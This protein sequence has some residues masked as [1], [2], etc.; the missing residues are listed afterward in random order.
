MS[1]GAIEWIDIP[2]LDTT[3]IAKFYASVFGWKI[4]HDPR[5]VGYPMFTDA[6]GNIGGGF[7]ASGRPTGDAGVMLYITVDDIDAALTRVEAEG[8]VSVQGK[9][10]IHSLVGWFAVF[11]DPA[12]NG[13]GLFQRVRKV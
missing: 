10:E 4:E 5:F 2:A 13:M 8:G 12:G 11:R 7:W 1:H 6:G 3:A 9:T